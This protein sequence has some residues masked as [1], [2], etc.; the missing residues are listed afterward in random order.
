MNNDNYGISISLP[1]KDATTSS[2]PQLGFNTNYP[3]AKIDT[4]NPN[5]YQ[6]FLLIITTDPPEPAG[7]TGNNYTYT[8][9][10]K[11]KHGY[12]YTPQH[13]SLIWVEQPGAGTANS[14]TYALD[15]CVISRHSAYDQAALIMVAGDTYIYIV[16]QKFYDSGTGI[17]QHNL[18]TGTNL[19]ITTHVFADD[20]GV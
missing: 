2:G 17:G 5:A 13:E 3:F 18:L 9:L 1:G 15:L 7:T 20:I 4:Q 12:T 10:Y 6:S 19:K 11:F 8:L 14:Q 16:C